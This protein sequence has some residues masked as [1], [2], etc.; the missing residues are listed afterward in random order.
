MES[1]APALT[2][3]AVLTAVAPLAGQHIPTALRVDAAASRIY[4]VTHRTGLLKFFGHEHAILPQKWT[5]DLCW[6]EGAHAASRAIIVVDARTLE[7]DADSARMLAGLG[8]GPSPQQRAQIHAKLHDQ[9]NLATTQFPELR[10]QSS[11]IRVDGAGRL[12]V[13]GNLSIKGVTREVALPV[14]VQR[15]NEVIRLTGRV[16]FRQSEFGIKPESIAGVVKVADSV[17]LY[18]DLAARPSGRSCPG[19]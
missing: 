5:A 10:F 9:D 16:G 1:R 6:E 19:S 13:R 3:A 12:E 18:V 4:V 2:F 8:K 14:T 7:I 15:T 11:Q 17:D